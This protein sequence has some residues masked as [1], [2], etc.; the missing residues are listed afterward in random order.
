MKRLRTAL[1]ALAALS[2]FT[3]VVC[4]DSPTALI[5]E[6]RGVSASRGGQALIGVYNSQRGWPAGTGRYTGAK[7]RVNGST[8]Q[9]IFGGLKDGRYAV[10]VGYD[11]NN[12]G[13]IDKNWVGLP[14]YVE[15][16]T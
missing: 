6:V 10:V 8:V 15:R 7:A 2:S 4:A 16:E 13:T 5:V 11:V 12:N 9:H 3:S 14:A 1:L